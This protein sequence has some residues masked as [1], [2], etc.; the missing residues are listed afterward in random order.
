MA[1]HENRPLDSIA[2]S[3]VVALISTMSRSDYGPSAEH[4]QLMRELL[5]ACDR[6]LRPR[7]EES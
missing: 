3:R 4:S 5:L 2:G 6:S 7:F 1:R